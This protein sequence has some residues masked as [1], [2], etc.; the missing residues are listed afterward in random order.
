MTW[1]IPPRSELSEPFD[2]RRKSRDIDPLR[3]SFDTDP[4]RWSFNADPLLWRAFLPRFEP[5]SFDAPDDEEDNLEW[6]ESFEPDSISFGSISCD[7]DP[8]R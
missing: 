2:L 6:S 3:W 1:S 7:T 4:L 8:L 5:T